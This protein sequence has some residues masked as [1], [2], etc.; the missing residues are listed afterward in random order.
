M[1]SPD[2]VIPILAWLAITGN[3]SAI[4]LGVLDGVRGQ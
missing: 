1:L 2:V 3:L 4:V